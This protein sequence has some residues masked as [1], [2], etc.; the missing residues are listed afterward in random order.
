ME[1]LSCLLVICALATAASADLIVEFDGS[2]GHPHDTP[3]TNGANAYNSGADTVYYAGVNG[4][5]SWVDEGDGSHKGMYL[6]GDSDQLQSLW[7]TPGGSYTFDGMADDDTLFAWN[8]ITTHGNVVIFDNL[9]A[10]VEN[11]GTMYRSPLVAGDP[12]LSDPIVA[13]KADLDDTWEQFDV[14]TASLVENGATISLADLDD[15]TSFG[16]TMAPSGNNNNVFTSSFEVYAVPEPA[17]L[18]LL[19]LGGLALIRRRRR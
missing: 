8:S 13:T 9:Y 4:M 16:M 12:G 6:Y 1:K 3:M 2:H 11:D 19:G 18:S 5:L 10:L 14:S 7:W 15:I 17:T